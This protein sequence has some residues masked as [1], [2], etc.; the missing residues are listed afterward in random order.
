MMA[1]IFLTPVQIWAIWLDEDALNGNCLT[2]FP[3]M[4]KCFRMMKSLLLSRFTKSYG[5]PPSLIMCFYCFLVVF[6]SL[7]PCLWLWHIN[8][9]LLIP[10]VLLPAPLSPRQCHNAALCQFCTMKG[11]QALRQFTRRMT[12]SC[13]FSS[14]G[15]CSDNRAKGYGC[16][17][18]GALLLCCRLEGQRSDSVRE[19]RMC[20]VIVSH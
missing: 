8:N 14:S 10:S 3:G 20:K 11:S 19:L 13:I 5:L 15:A 12:D 16:D 4:K 9:F 18:V 7:I 17:R 1:I 6:L 2:L